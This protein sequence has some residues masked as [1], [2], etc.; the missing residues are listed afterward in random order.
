MKIKG[1][2]YAW[3]L[4]SV[5]LVVGFFVLPVVFIKPR[6]SEILQTVLSCIQ[7]LWVCFPPIA[8]ILAFIGKVRSE[9]GTKARSLC[10]IG[11][12]IGWIESVVLMFH[13]FGALWMDVFPIPTEAAE[14][15]TFVDTFLIAGYFLIGYIRG[16]ILW[17]I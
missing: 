7:I 1:R 5:I 4:S 6:E 11:A 8:F 10:N 16:K 12:V 9:G 3:G 13:G 17:F 2:G 14:I 15:A